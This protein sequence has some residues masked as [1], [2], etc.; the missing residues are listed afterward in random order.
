MELKRTADSSANE[1]Q[2]LRHPVILFD[3]VCNYCNGNINFLIRRDQH[4]RLRFCTMQSEKGKELL[5]SAGLR[6]DYLN[7]I[8]FIEKGKVTL[9]S[10][11]ALRTLLYVHG[12][13]RLFFVLIIIPRFIRDA[14]YKLFA[15]NRYRIFGKRSACM[16]PGEN[17]KARFLS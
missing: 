7:T 15:M 16:I 17:V 10:T 1:L 11:A 12:L 8:V 14:V 9:A 5:V 4:S 6:G 2:R 13:W 3:G